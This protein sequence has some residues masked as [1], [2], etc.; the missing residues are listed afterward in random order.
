MEMSISRQK[1]HIFS[2]FFSILHKEQYFS[3]T[4]STIKSLHLVYINRD[5]N[6]SKVF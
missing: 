6:S 3:Y 4:F 5:N 1:V 2:K